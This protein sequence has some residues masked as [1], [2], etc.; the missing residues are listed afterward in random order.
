MPIE[1][2]MK[3][4]LGQVS[5]SLRELDHSNLAL[6]ISPYVTLESNNL[7]IS[8]QI[9]PQ[10][11]HENVTLKAKIN[12]DY[13]T[14]IGTVETQEDGRFMY[15]WVPLNGG[16]LTVQAS[17]VGNRQYNGAISAEINVVVLP[18]LIVVIVAALVIIL[19]MFALAVVKIIR[20]KPTQSIQPQETF[21]SP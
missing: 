8:G 2:V 19:I 6:Q 12:S 17:W 20:K 21:S 9:L 16:V 7:T 14:T 5:V 1:N 13:W 18:M 11:A 3:T 4:Y 10:S 15:S